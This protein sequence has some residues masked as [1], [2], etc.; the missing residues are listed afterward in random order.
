MWK[1]LLKKNK[2]LKI[3]KCSHFKCDLF[4]TFL[5][6]R[7][8]NRSRVVTPSICYF[9]SGWDTNKVRQSEF[10]K[11]LALFC[12]GVIGFKGF[13]PKNVCFI[14]QTRL[15]KSRFKR[16]FCPTPFLLVDEL[17]NI[18]LLTAYRSTSLTAFSIA[19]LLVKLLAYFLINN[20]RCHT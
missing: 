14:P 6:S 15:V 3:L 13:V 20:F 10:A 5:K 1:F 2:R 7:W 12:W 8:H 4:L 17:P 18:Q 11:I 16:F 9:L 19:R